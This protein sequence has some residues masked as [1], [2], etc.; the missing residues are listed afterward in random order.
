[1]LAVQIH[2]GRQLQQIQQKDSAAL[3]A[4]VRTTTTHQQKQQQL[5]NTT[6]AR[7]SS[8]EAKAAAAPGCTTDETK[9]LNGRIDHVVKLI[10]DRGVFNGPDT[11]SSTV[12][13][14]KT[15]ITMLQTRPD[16]ATKSYKMP[17]FDINK[18]DALAW[19]QHFLTEASCRT[20]PDDYMMKA[21]Y[22][23]LI[24][25]AQAWMNHLAATHTCAIAEL[26]THITWKEFEQLWFT[27]FM[28][29]NVVKAAM[30]EVYTCSQ[31]SMPTRDWTTKWQQI[32]TTPGFDLTF[33]NQRS[34]F[35]SRSCA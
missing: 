16:T 23:Q 15:D 3:S 18:T 14:I 10:G 32:V 30:N 7:V 24:G 22:L 35:F 17:H 8:I 28:V 13:A 6:T 31:G 11:I 34:E 20:V 12:A 9:Q 25:G 33:S 26:H 5:W 4:A 1:M 29:R 19:W 27:R 21:L 2:K